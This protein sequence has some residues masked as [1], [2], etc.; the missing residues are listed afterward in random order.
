MT[1]YTHDPEDVYRWRRAMAEALAASGVEV[2][3][4]G[5]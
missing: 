5:P 4:S 3:L 2:T 1:A